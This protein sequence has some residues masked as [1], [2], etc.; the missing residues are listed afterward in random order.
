MRECRARHLRIKVFSS[1][2]SPNCIFAGQR[3]NKAVISHR[4]VYR[5]TSFSVPRSYAFDAARRI[6]AAAAD[7]TYPSAGH[8]A[9]AEAIPT[10]IPQTT[11]ARTKSVGSIARILP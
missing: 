5:C 7:T 9:A 10:M 11:R 8:I 4:L 2:V 6:T 1:D 3:Q